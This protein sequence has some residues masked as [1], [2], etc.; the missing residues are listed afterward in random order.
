MMEYADL[1]IKPL[2]LGQKLLELNTN[3]SHYPVMNEANE[4][5]GIVDSEGA[6]DEWDDQNL[7]VNPTLVIKQTSH[8]LSVMMQMYHFLYFYCSL[9]TRS[10]KFDP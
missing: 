5:I 1:D 3:Y 10:F 2:L 7:I 8:I 6:A 4:L 9:L